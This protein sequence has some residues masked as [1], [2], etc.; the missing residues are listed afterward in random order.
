MTQRKDYT[1]NTC[2]VK[3]E[4]TV[5]PSEGKREP[6]LM[7]VCLSLL[8]RGPY[9]EEA[10]NP[11]PSGC[12]KHIIESREQRQSQGERELALLAKTTGSKQAFANYFPRKQGSVATL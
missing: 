8:R 3:N 9:K 5:K 4:E 6:V 2:R 1:E 10:K 11:G 7:A 12:S